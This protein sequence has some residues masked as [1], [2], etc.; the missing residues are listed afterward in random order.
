MEKQQPRIKNH[1]ETDVAYMKKLTEEILT[2]VQ[3]D[4]PNVN[5][6]NTHVER[7]H[8]PIGRLYADKYIFIPDRFS[9]NIPTHQD[10]ISGKY[11]NRT[12]E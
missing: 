4:N 3:P 6:S 7:T 9:M 12:G 8:N 10:V 11:K 5:K 2:V 1:I